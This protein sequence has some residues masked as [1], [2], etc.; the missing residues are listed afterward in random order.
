RPDDADH[1]AGRHIEGDVVQDFPP[2]DAIT[3]SDMIERDIATDCQQ[4]RSRRQVSR[5]GSRVE[6]VAKSQDRQARLVKILPDLRKAQ[7][8]RVDSPGQD[9]ESNELA[10]RQIAL[11]DQL[12]AEIEDAGSDELTDEL[13]H[14]TCSVAEAQ[15]AETGR[16]VTGELLFPSPLH[17]RLDGHGL[18]R[19][20]PSDALDKKGLILGAPLK[21]LVQP[22]TK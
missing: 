22:L 18:K 1:L 7:H 15:N 14:L 17:L 6:D 3:E 19:L 11:N 5:F 12:G 16:D 8:R 21:F 20:N 9:I 4:P 10:H 13:H 2:V